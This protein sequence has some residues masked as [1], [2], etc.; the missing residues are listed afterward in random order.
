MSWE[1]RAIDIAQLELQSRREL[2]LSIINPNLQYY[3]TPISPFIINEET[4]TCSTRKFF[5][6]DQIHSNLSEV[7]L[8]GSVYLYKLYEQDEYG[9]DLLP[10]GNKNYFLRYCVCIKRRKIIRN[11]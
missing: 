5:S 10:T 8:H 7:S 4:L 11:D 6:M 1:Q 9:T 2:S 3:E